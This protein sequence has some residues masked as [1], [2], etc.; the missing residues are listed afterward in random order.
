ML[1]DLMKNPLSISN[2]K[3]P[4]KKHKVFLACFEKLGIALDRWNISIRYTLYQIVCWNF[5]VV[6]LRCLSLKGGYLPEFDCITCLMVISI[7][8]NFFFHCFGLQYL[9]CYLSYKT[10]ISKSIFLFRRKVMFCYQDIQV[11]AFLT[12]RQDD[13]VQ[14]TG[15]IFEYI[16]RTTIN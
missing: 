15:Y 11:F 4:R 14:E 3:L 16:F 8:N 6:V 9:K 13:R 10:M 7:Q 12:R 2:D 5:Q 1:F